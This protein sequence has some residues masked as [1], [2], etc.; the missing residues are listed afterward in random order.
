M[1]P[2]HLEGRP[3]ATAAVSVPAQM[4][5]VLQATY[6]NMLKLRLRSEEAGC[7]FFFKAALH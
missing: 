5:H 1:L 3:Q 6:Q 2:V 7:L 4:A